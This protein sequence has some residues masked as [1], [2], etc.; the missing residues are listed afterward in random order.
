MAMSM[1]ARQDL[2]RRFASRQHGAFRLCKREL[3]AGC[4]IVC[5]SSG[6]KPLGF[7]VRRVSLLHCDVHCIRDWGITLRPPPLETPAPR[8]GEKAM[9]RAMRL[10]AFA[11][12]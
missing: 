1:S 11:A 7:E 8:D 10:Q 6:M 5:G 4:P 3:A 12:S 2:Q 9:L